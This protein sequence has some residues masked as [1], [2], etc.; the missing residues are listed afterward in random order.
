M[1]I[2]Q[3][4]GKLQ[5]SYNF[6]IFGMLYL[7]NLET[8]KKK[9]CFYYL[10]GINT[11]QDSLD[12]F[13]ELNSFH[14]SIIHGCSFCFEEANN[15]LTYG[16][17]SDNKDLFDYII[18][19]NIYQTQKWFYSLFEPGFEF[20]L[21][22]LVKVNSAVLNGIEYRIKTTFDHPVRTKILKGSLRK[23]PLNLINDNRVERETEYSLLKEKIESILTEIH[24]NNN[25]SLPEIAQFYSDFLK[26]RPF[27]MGNGRTLRILVNYLFFKADFPFIYFEESDKD[28][29]QEAMDC[30]IN[31]S[32]EKLIDYFLYRIEKSLAILEI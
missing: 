8:I 10:N 21:D 32:H 16:E 12:R 3:N 6:V 30:S 17:T 9:Y 7:H 13:L 20:N 25:I 14:S 23:Q 31:G 15:F 27:D 4:I 18:L 5:I 1:T 2:H 19:S 22:V 28:I 24:Y 29:Y 11:S 26:L